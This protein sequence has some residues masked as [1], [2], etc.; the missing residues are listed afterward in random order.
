MSKLLT[1]LLLAAVAIAVPYFL[2]RKMR[3]PRRSLFAYAMGSLA[4]GATSTAVSLAAHAMLPAP[5]LDVDGI[6]GSG[7]ACAVVGPALGVWAGK[8]ARTRIHAGSQADRRRID[9]APSTP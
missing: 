3:Q 5:A 4:S 9:P 2:L 8:R 6:V 7:L 1:I